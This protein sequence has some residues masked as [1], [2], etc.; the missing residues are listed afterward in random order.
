MLLIVKV[1]QAQIHFTFAASHLTGHLTQATSIFCA[2]WL[3]PMPNF[4]KSDIIDWRWICRLFP[5]T[6]N[7]CAAC[8]FRWSTPGA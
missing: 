2:A 1:K 3:R 5:F 8:L 6:W 4:I 7:N